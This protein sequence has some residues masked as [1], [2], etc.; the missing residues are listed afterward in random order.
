MW[1]N[2]HPLRCVK[3]DCISHLASW[4]YFK[5][6]ISVRGWPGWPPGVPPTWMILSPTRTKKVPRYLPQHMSKK[7]KE[8]KEKSLKPKMLLRQTFRTGLVCTCRCWAGKR[9][10][11]SFLSRLW[12]FQGR[13]AGTRQNLSCHLFWVS[14]LSSSK[15]HKKDPGKLF[16][17]WLYHS[18]PQYSF[19]KIQ[20]ILLERR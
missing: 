18:C 20:G 1:L 11:D 17:A 9:P 6:D 15:E 16:I 2:F 8:R 10:E 4:S 7:K 3:L 12:A 19:H 14:Q 5:M 13:H